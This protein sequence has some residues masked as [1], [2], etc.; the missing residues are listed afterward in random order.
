MIFLISQY[1]SFRMKPLPGIMPSTM[2]PVVT[3]PAIVPLTIKQNSNCTT[4]LVSWTI[5][6]FVTIGASHGSICIM[7]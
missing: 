2:G 3:L 1:S 5:R 7:M 4:D 6:L